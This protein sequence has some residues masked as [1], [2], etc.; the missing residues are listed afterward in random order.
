MSPFSF[1]FCSFYI[2]I[3]YNFNLLPRV[4]RD[5]RNVLPFG[6]P[7]RVDSMEKVGEGLVALGCLDLFANGGNFKNGS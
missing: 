6:L 3:A 2:F 4:W 1:S 7:G 5:N